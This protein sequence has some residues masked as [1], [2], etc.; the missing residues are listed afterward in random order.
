MTRDCLG[1]AGAGDDLI[2]DAVTKGKGFVV[3][4]SAEIITMIQ[5][6]GDK[7]YGEKT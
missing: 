4:C 1:V 3:F 5:E 6:S 7:I 2:E